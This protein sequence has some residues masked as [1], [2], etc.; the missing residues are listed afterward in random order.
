M[1]KVYK[2]WTSGYI[3][4]VRR[5]LEYQRSKLVEL[6]PEALQRHRE[7]PRGPGRGDPCRS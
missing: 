3:G 5:V 1:L 4:P 7:V 2:E 6:S